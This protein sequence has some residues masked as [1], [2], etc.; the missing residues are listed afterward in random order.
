MLAPQSFITKHLGV[1]S[2]L[3]CIFIFSFCNLCME[4]LF[5]ELCFLELL[6][7]VFEYGT[8]ILHLND[9]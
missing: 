9:K 8:N 3:S 6:F 2:V 1:V 5:L 7:Y 4:F